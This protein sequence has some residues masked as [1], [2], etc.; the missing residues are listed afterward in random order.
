M[1]L[2][3]TE[4]ENENVIVFKD[5]NMYIKATDYLGEPTEFTPNVELALSFPNTINFKNSRRVLLLVDKGYK[6][7]NLTK[8]TIYEIHEE[9]A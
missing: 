2:K 5:G 1:I 7:I 4:V 9:D 3:R 8:K 6:P